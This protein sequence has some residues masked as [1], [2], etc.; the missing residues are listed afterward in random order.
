MGCVL[1]SSKQSPHQ[2]EKTKALT[3]DFNGTTT[4]NIVCCNKKFSKLKIIYEVSP[5]EEVSIN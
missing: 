1:I 2:R 3:L 4:K 5:D